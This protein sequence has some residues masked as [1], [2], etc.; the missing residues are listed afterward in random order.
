MEHG[1]I[2]I[3]KEFISNSFYERKVSFVRAISSIIIQIQA[4]FEGEIS[5]KNM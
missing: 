1:H 2:R 5:Y 3:F 4:Y